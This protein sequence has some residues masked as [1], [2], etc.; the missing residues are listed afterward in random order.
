MSNQAAWLDGIGKSLRIGEAPMPGPKDDEILI[1][2]RATAI[3]PVDN[4]QVREGWEVKTWPYILGQDVAGDITA[5]GSE[6]KDFN[7]GDRVI[8][9]LWAITTGDTSEGGFALYAKVLARNAAHLPDDVDYRDGAVLPVALDTAISGL[10][11]PQGSL[12]LPLPSFNPKPNASVL[13]IY[14]GSSSVG[15]S[16]TQLA[17]ASGLRVI[18]TASPRN[19]AISKSAG[20]HTTLDYRDPD[21]VE[22][23]IRAVGD[24]KLVGIYDAVS[25]ESTYAHD[26]A[27]LKHFGGGKLVT[28]LDPPESL[29]E[30]VQVQFVFGQGK[31]LLHVWD[32]YIKEAVSTKKLKFLPAPLVVGRGLESFQ[33]GL[34]RLAEGVSAQKVVVEL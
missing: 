8:A 15:L 7:I 14:G 23:V 3:N 5:V 20:A 21:L 6:V 1:R 16:T 34:E 30:N 24:D 31:D 11:A 29:P 22:K 25:V 9:H 17:V 26:L 4:D 27:I 19:H 28:V 2:I 10:Y 33:K 12:N 18:A 13:L 32:S